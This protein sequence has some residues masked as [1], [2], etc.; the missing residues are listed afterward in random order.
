MPR[1]AALVVYPLEGGRGLRVKAGAVGAQG[2]EGDRRWRV[3]T[4][5]GAVL[6]ADD[7]P[8][9]GKIWVEQKGAE[10]W[11]AVAGMD[12]LTLPLASIEVEHPAA[13]AW[14]SRFLDRP[15]RCVPLASQGGR[16]LATTTASLA[17]LNQRLAEPTGIERFRPNLVIEGTRPFEE[18]EWQA[19]QLGGARFAV[20][21][22][23][24]EPST[25]PVFQALA[26]FRAREGQ[27]HFGIDLAVSSAVQLRA[28]QTLEVQRAS[29]STSAT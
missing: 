24:V 15:V 12:R 17:E 25:D 9:L 4:E 7:E 23:S 8:R 5:A 20:T 29:R 14:F 16:L 13:D 6:A 3:T 19:V 2:L 21:A 11:L 28:G 1:I 18:D 27:V 26:S 10:L 22:S